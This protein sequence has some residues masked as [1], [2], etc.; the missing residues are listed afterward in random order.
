MFK[1]PVNWGNSTQRARRSVCKQRGTTMI[2][3][4]VAALVLSAGLLGLAAMQ[5]QALK[6]ASGLATQQ[7]MVQALGAYSE[8]RLTAPSSTGHYLN[9]GQLTSAFCAGLWLAQQPLVYSDTSNQTILDMDY[10][11]TFV[12]TYTPCGSV[13]VT[14]FLEYRNF[15]VI[16]GSEGIE[17]DYVSP[18]SRRAQC[19]L[20]TGEVIALWNMALVR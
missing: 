13:A 19:T 3:I 17:C 7:V 2:E 4:M 20:P 11:A 18:V 16:A 9:P 15:F 10:F 5:T 8:A 1:P 14:E 6:T 12:G